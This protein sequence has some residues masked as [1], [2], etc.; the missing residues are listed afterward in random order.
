MREA[1]HVLFRESIT[2]EHISHICGDSCC[3][4]SVHGKIPRPCLHDCLFGRCN[5]GY[6]DFL[7][8]L[9]FCTC[10]ISALMKLQ[11]N[12]KVVFMKDFYKQH[13]VRLIIMLHQE[14]IIISGWGKDNSRQ[15][16]GKYRWH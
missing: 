4:W 13:K 14:M 11:I 5:R 8:F 6:D 12:Q 10:S 16:Q 1:Q 9:Y 7:F 15:Y 2:G 3:S